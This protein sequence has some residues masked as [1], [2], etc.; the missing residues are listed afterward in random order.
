MRSD[1]FESSGINLEP[2]HGPLGCDLTSERPPNRTLIR[3]QPVLHL[4][5]RQRSRSRISLRPRHSNGS[6]YFCGMLAKW[7]FM[8]LLGPVRPGAP[9]S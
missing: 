6:S 5:L 4:T 2:H 8:K 9:E 3:D 7:S 1:V